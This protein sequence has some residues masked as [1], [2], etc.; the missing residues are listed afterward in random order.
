MFCLYV[1]EVR[2]SSS[3]EER[4][5]L[6]RKIEAMHGDG[7]HS[8]YARRTYILDIMTVE[9][10]DLN[11]Q[12]PPNVSHDL[13]RKHSPSQ[14]APPFARIWCES[15]LNPDDFFSRYKFYSKRHS[16]IVC[17]VLPCCVLVMFW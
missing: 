12:V 16:T 15:A 3:S 13:S 11:M 4:R 1:V 7:R 2:D 8:A 17:D 9:T 6:K 5:C 14:K 10:L